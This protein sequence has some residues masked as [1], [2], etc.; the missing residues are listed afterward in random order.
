MGHVLNGTTPE[1]QHRKWGPKGSQNRG[2]WSAPYLI[3]R[4]ITVRWEG[5]QNRVPWSATDLILTCLFGKSWLCCKIIYYLC[6]QICFSTC[7]HCVFVI[8]DYEKFQV[9]L[10][11]VTNQVQIDWGRKAI[12]LLKSFSLIF[13]EFQ[14]NAT[15][16]HPPGSSLNRVDHGFP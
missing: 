6:L 2:P 4:E 1:I 12:K 13:L 5:I 7:W 10:K 14:Q 15:S 11:N 9:H 3:F 16:L 8:S